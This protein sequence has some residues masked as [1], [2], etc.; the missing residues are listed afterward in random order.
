MTALKINL[1]KL[2][3]WYSLD[4]RS[5]VSALRADIRAERD[6]L[7]GKTKGGGDF[8]SPFWADAKISLISGVSLRSLTALRVE[9]SKQ[10]RRL[11]PLLYKGFQSWIDGLRRRTNEKVGWS[12]LNIHNHLD[13]DDL[14]LTLKVDNLLVLKIGDKKRLVYP[15][16]SER[17]ILSEKIARIG[18]WAMAEALEDESITEM[19]ILDV[20]RVVSYKGDRTILKGEEEADFH[21]TF[22]RI[23]KRRR[24]LRREYDL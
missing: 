16:F 15:Y 11:Y 18:L 5:L 1:N 3:K 21:R 24:E 13:F 4:E 2:L 17:P 23:A 6:K 10:R 9:S 19:E 20:L 7:E 8:H 14:N 12:E 22:R